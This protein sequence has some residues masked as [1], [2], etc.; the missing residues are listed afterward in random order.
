MKSCVIA[1]AGNPNSGKTTLFNALTGSNQYVG[2][3]PGVTI[4]K[5][6]GT[7][8][9][10]PDI[11]IQDLPGIYSL[12]ASSLEEEIAIKQLTTKRPGLILN[13]VDATNLERNL[14][15]TMQLLELGLPVLLCLN[16]MDLVHQSGAV[17]DLDSLSKMLDCPVVGISAMKGDGLP[18]LK[19]KAVKCLKQIQGG[20][21]KAPKKPT[22]TEKVE[23]SLVKVEDLIKVFV[24]DEQL[25]FW[26]VQVLEGNNKTVSQMLIPAEKQDAAAELTKALEDSQ[27][28]DAHSLLAFER[29]QII[30]GIVSSAQK[31]KASEHISLSDKIDRVVTQRWLALPIFVT[32]M[33]VVY[34]ISVTSVGTLVTDWT[35]DVLFGE[36]VPQWVAKFL[37]LLNADV[38][39]RS[40]ILDG[41][42][43]GM[44]A[45]LGFIPQM[46]ILFVFL[47][48]LEGSGYLAR[49]AFIMDRIFRKFGLSGK[50]FI[51][52]LIGSGC[53]VPGIMASRTI[54]EQKDRRMTIMLTSF[55]P[56]S[57]KLPVIALLAGALFGGKWWVSPSAYFLGIA[58]VIISGIL[59][60]KTKPFRGP[61]VPF[62]M[63]LPAYRWP[64]IGFIWRSTWERASSFIKKAGTI[65][66]LS[67]IVIWFL[68]NIGFVDG[69]LVLVEDLSDGFLS[70]IGNAI[71]WVFSPLGWGNWKASVAAITGLVAKEN[72]VNTFGILYAAPEDEL[73]LYK[74]VAQSFTTIAAYSF[75]IFNLL[76]A[77]C[78][79]A[80]GAIRREMNSAAWTWFAIA[81]QTLFAYSAALIFYQTALWLQTGLFTVW[82]GIGLFVLALILFLLF[83]PD[84]KQREAKLNFA[85]ETIQ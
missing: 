5:K 36:I 1:L 37:D 20:I 85:S 64:S 26:A 42:I 56:C 77:P 55:I 17:F 41:I 61:A 63:E 43:A 66:F 72:I 47:A 13:I 39:M 7:L 35:N 12:S 3:W 31:K 10:H 18:E 8:K 48:F 15:L 59:L 50:S 60:K 6:E 81:Y 58:A 45:V 52:M 4:E 74:A 30:N 57:A 76:C 73:E 49:V 67:S 78:F 75:M 25:R 46:L 82:T 27:G 22:Y 23:E 84:S 69:R 51:P 54:E 70:V 2:N 38:W 28:D 79:A 62:V 71:A 14:Y 68:S 21:Q 29:Y 40:L 32:V 24:P 80:I 19:A 33:F 34:Y 11:L 44:G 65:I 16:M 83:R 9:D 53:S